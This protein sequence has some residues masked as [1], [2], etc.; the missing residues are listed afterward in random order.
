MEQLQTA[1][2]DL[3]NGDLTKNL[4]TVGTAIASVGTAAEDLFTQLKATCGS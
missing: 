4:K 1:V 3:G 2:G